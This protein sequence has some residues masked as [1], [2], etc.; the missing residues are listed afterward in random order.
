MLSKN[1]CEL[2]S[3][4]KKGL[5]GTKK[6]SIDGGLEDLF[7]NKSFWNLFENPKDKKDNDNRGLFFNKY[8]ENNFRLFEDKNNINYEKEKNDKDKNI[9]LFNNKENDT[10]NLKVF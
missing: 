1:S 9:N 7:Q 3:E 8:N 6:N 10:K 4:S 5:F 2:F